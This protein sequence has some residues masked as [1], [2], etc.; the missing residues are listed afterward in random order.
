MLPHDPETPGGL[1]LLLVDELCET[2]GVLRNLGP[3]CVWCE[4]L[5]EKSRPRL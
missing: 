1:G 2:W 5:L 3:T 4:L